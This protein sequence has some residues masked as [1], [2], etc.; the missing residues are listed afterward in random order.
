MDIY[1]CSGDTDGRV[2]VTS[3]RLSVNQLQLPVSAKWRPWFSNTK[4]LTYTHLF[5]GNNQFIKRECT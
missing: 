1:L 2:P 4:V 5:L 3:S